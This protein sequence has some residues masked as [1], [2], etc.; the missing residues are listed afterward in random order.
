MDQRRLTE[1]QRHSDT[2][3]GEFED[4][5]DCRPVGPF[6]VGAVT[7]RAEQP[8]RER[9]GTAILALGGGEAPFFQVFVKGVNLVELFGLLWKQVHSGHIFTIQDGDSGCAHATSLPYMR[10]VCAAMN[11][12]RLW[13]KPIAA[14][15][16]CCM[17]SP[18]S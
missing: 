8:R 18:R 7:F 2:F 11:P 9:F 3:L 15:G 17:A 6:H 12:L 16:T 1:P 14:S 13:V 5:S 4:S 10:T